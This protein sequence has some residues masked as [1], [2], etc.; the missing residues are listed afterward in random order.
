VLCSMA[1]SILK[2]RMGYD[3]SLD[4]FGVHGLGGTLG[5]IL[6]GVFATEAVWNIGPNKP[7]GLLEGGPVLKAQLIATGATWVFAAVVTFVLLKT[8]D[9]TMG[10]RV[11]LDNEMEGLDVSQHNEEGYIFN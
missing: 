9:A 8:L 2:P 3:D 5:A 11:S 7:L 6:T 10:L 1:C 4:A